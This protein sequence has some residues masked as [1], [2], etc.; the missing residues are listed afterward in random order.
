MKEDNNTDKET[1]AQVERLKIQALAA[2]IVATYS[3]RCKVLTAYQ[4]GKSSGYSVKQSRAA[5]KVAC[6]IWEQ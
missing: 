4:L 3:S 1:A 2:K 6:N 5:Y